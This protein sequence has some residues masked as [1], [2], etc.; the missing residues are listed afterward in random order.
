MSETP[1]LFNRARVRQ[2][3][4]RAAAAFGAHDF[5]FREVAGR[6][7]DRLLDIKRTFPTAL[8]MGCHDGTLA[9]ILA[10]TGIG[11]TRG[12][13]TMVQMDL[14]QPMAAVARHVTPA[15]TTPALVADEE[16]LPFADGAFDLIM[17][18]MSLH[19]VND[20]PG[21]LIQARRALKPDGL[22]LAALPGRGTLHELAHVLLQAEDEVEG[23]TSPHVAPFADVRDLGN[24][25]VRT[26]FALAVADGETVTVSYE[27]PLK[28]MDDL[29]A[30]GEGNALMAR[31]TRS[32]T[33]ATRARAA[34]IY[35]ETFADADGRVPATFEVVTLTGWA[36]DASQPKPLQPGSAKH[37]LKDAL[38]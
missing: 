32:L 24:L 20:L 35:V 17:S 6:L 36:P 2:N 8:D 9:R 10:E 21:A 7:A 5:L 26:G 12:I 38:E 11:R 33:P 28:L 16:T 13:E 1:L 34:E 25:L 15:P 29:C 23:G 30:M 37:S 27:S 22:F 4:E 18:V 19:W 14:A 3:R 31:R